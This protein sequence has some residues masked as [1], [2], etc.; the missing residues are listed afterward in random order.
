M[1]LSAEDCRK[2]AAECDALAA[3]DKDKVVREQ[4]AQLAETWRELATMLGRRRTG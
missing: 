1:S 3:R 2:Y 4:L